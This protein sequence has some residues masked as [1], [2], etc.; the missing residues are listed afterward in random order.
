VNRGEELPRPRQLPREITHFTGREAELDI[1]DALI[2]DRASQYPATVVIS[3]IAGAPGIGKTSLAVHWAHRV[4]DRFPDGQLYVNLRGDDR[5][6]ATTA[7][8]V[9]NSFLLALGQPSWR[10]PQDAEAKEALY[11][12]LLA[13]R[14][15]LVLLDNAGSPGQIRPLLPNEPA[16]LVLVTSR[17]RLSGL[18]ARDGAFRIS[19]DVLEPEHACQ[20]LD[21]IVDVGRSTRN[22]EM[23]AEL[24]RQCAY[25]P[26]ALR[27][28]AERVAGRRH[29]T[30]ADM[31]RELA[32]EHRR[33]DV[34]AADDDETTA[35]RAVFSSSYH[36]LS[37]DTARMF[38]LLG[39]H[40]GP[41][42]SGE[43]ASSL[44]D[45][46]VAETTWHLDR[47][48]GVHLLTEAERGRYQFHDLLRA[49]AAELVELDEP[50]D[51]RE[52]ATQRLFEWYLHS[53]HAA[54][55]AF[56]PQH[57]EIPV[58]PRRPSCRPMVFAERDSA[59]VW[60]DAERA[61]LMAIINHAPAV[62]Q[63]AVGWQLPNAFDC[64]LCEYPVA[65][66]IAIHEL[67]LAAA[68]HVGHELGKRWAYGHLGEAM[69]D[70]RRYDD[71]IECH[72]QAL[73]IGRKI[74]HKFG[75]GAALGDLGGA[76]NALGRY[77]EA[78]EYCRQALEIYRTIGHL[79]N[80]SLNLVQWGIALCGMGHLDEASVRIQDGLDIMTRT[81]AVNS[82]A[83]ALRELAKVRHLQGFSDEAV[84][85]LDLAAARCREQHLER[86]YGETL[87][88]LGSVLYDVGSTVKA[89]EAWQEACVIL[90]DVDPDRAAR[91]GERLVSFS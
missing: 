85:H 25:L 50:A 21:E 9:L 31:V 4:Q 5:R 23:L 42:I 64:Y 32:V 48:A 56:Y 38:R 68:R 26:L 72:L 13:G 78:A 75:E 45:A 15:V 89:R 34:L 63:Y 43:A 77:A 65:D 28:A 60:F 73:E 10:I 29:L 90:A 1:L 40:P 17:S 39:L 6:T 36:A 44:I 82:Q 71:A 79:R 62:G 58:E 35:V 12:T 84:A 52:A 91:I 33:L 76:Y 8:Q 87:D 86:S 2:E 37:R 46:S 67:G 18:V 24:A 22:R 54:L 16:C 11:R 41:S 49:Y 14:K 47:L 20:L 27:I 81:G 59:R 57:P 30:I 70:A 66:R 83:W 55:F 61:N 53:T 88:E 19:L 80:E 74:G 69:Q 51:S 7:D 3:A